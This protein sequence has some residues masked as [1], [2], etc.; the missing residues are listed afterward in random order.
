MTYVQSSESRKLLHVFH[1]SFFLRFMGG[2]KGNH[3]NLNAKDIIVHIHVYNNVIGHNTTLS[4]SFLH[5][6]WN[7]HQITYKVTKL[8]YI[9]T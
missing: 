4:F 2:V 3:P 1:H 8:G 9:L 7:H 6:L 5:D